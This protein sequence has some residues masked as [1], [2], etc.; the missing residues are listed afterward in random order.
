MLLYTSSINKGKDNISKY[1]YTSVVSKRLM[2]INPN[3]VIY[4]LH[5]TNQ[6]KYLQMLLYNSCMNKIMEISPNVIGIHQLYQQN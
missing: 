5:Q 2:K 4:Q 3:V 1:Y 6:G